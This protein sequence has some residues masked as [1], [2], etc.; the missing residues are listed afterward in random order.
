MARSVSVGICAYNAKGRVDDALAS[1]FDQEVPKGFELVE[2]I[3]VSSGCTDGTDRA[4]EAWSRRNSSV[5]LFREPTRNGKISAL[6]II[7]ERYAGEILVLLNADARLEAG[8]LR[9]LLDAFRDP[10]VEIACGCPL[11]D[12]ARGDVHSLLQ[13]FLW[14]IHNSTLDALSNAR[15]ANHCCDEFMAMRRGFVDR[16]PT[17]LINDGAYFGVVSSLRRGTVRFCP[18]AKVYVRTPRTL[19]GLVKQRQRILRGH[20]QIR[21]ILHRG[22]NTLEEL[23]K[24]KPG[25]AARILLGEL[26]EHLRSF[27]VF[28]L[29]AVPLELLAMAFVASDELRAIAYEPAWPVVDQL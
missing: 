3:V 17:G 21:G 11:P 20:R 28:L 7:L 10:A 1:L 29:L 27:L 14:N 5:R 15:M 2:I 4:I 19:A 18:E 24:R 16:L 12:V 9:S 22:P 13:E 25:L 6:N 26:R 8:A 23:A